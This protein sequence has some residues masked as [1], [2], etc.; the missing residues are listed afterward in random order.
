MEWP[1]EDKHGCL[2]NVAAARKS[3]VEQVGDF[4][5]VFDDE[6]PHW[7]VSL[8]RSKP[9]ESRDLHDLCAFR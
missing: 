2:Q 7:A 6:D 5:F 4:R 3:E 9:A 8:N 1:R